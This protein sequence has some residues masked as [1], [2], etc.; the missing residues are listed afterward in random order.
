MVSSKS[1]KFP[2][3]LGKSKKN[4]IESQGSKISAGRWINNEDD[5]ENPPNWVKVPSEGYIIDRSISDIG[6]S[7]GINEYALITRY[8]DPKS[9]K[10]MIELLPVNSSAFDMENEP[11]GFDSCYAFDSDEDLDTGVFQFPSVAV[12]LGMISYFMKN[13]MDGELNEE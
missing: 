7:S 2:L 8:T 13:R 6:Y 1:V 12:G 10:P 3:P 9:M 4:T 5:L 11:D